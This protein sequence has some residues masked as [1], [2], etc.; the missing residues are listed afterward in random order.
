MDSHNS[1]ESSSS[2][3][4]N[5]FAGLAISRPI[6]E[7]EDD[8]HLPMPVM[9]HEDRLAE[10]MS[11]ESSDSETDKCE[12]EHE[13][14]HVSKGKPYENDVVET[15]VNTEKPIW[16]RKYKKNKQRKKQKQ[17]KPKGRQHGKSTKN[18]SVGNSKQASENTQNPTNKGI[19]G[20]HARGANYRQQGRSGSQSNDSDSDDGHKRNNNTKLP[21]GHYVGLQ[22]E[23]DEQMSVDKSTDTKAPKE[24]S[25]TADLVAQEGCVTEI[26]QLLDPEAVGLGRIWNFRTQG[27]DERQSQLAAMVANMVTHCSHPTNCDNCIKP[28]VCNLVRTWIRHYKSCSYRNIYC[29][30]CQY[31]V[32]GVTKHAL[33]CDNE[34]CEVPN[35]HF[36]RKQLLERNARKEIMGTVLHSTTSIFKEGQTVRQD[37]DYTYFHKQK[38]GHG[39]HG[40][41]HR[42]WFYHLW[43]EVEADIVAKEVTYDPKDEAKV[44]QAIRHDHPN[45]LG[46]TLVVRFPALC[47]KLYIREEK[48]I[49]GCIFMERGEQTLHDLKADYRKQYKCGLPIRDAVYYLRQTLEGLR[50][51]H[52]KKIVHK[53]IKDMNIMMFEKNQ[54]IKIS[55]WDGALFIK[56]E[57]SDADMN[58]VG[59]P[60]FCAPE[61]VA[62]RPHGYPADIFSAAIMLLELLYGGQYQEKPPQAAAQD[63]V[64]QAMLYNRVLERRRDA[65]ERLKREHRDLGEV[66]ERCLADNPADRPTAYQMVHNPLLAYEQN[67]KVKLPL[68]SKSG[69]NADVEPVDFCRYADL[70]GAMEYPSSLFEDK[71]RLYLT[72]DINSRTK[73][74][75]I[76]LPVGWKQFKKSE[77]GKFDFTFE[78]EIRKAAIQELEQQKLQEDHENEEKEKEKAVLASLINDNSENIETQNEQGMGELVNENGGTSARNDESHVDISEAPIL[79]PMRVDNDPVAQKTNAK[80]S[81]FKDFNFSE[82]EDN[83]A[84]PFELVELQT[85]DDIDELKSVLQPESVKNGTCTKKA[86]VDGRK[87]DADIDFSIFNTPVVTKK[88]TSPAKNRQVATASLLQG[89]EPDV[90]AAP[91]PSVAAS[92]SS[93]VTSYSSAVSSTFSSDLPTSMI[94]SDIPLESRFDLIYNKTSSVQNS[95]RNFMP[96]SYSVAHTSPNSSGRYGPAAFNTGNISAYAPVQF[97]PQTT[98]LNCARN[99]NGPSNTPALDSSRNV[100]VQ[101]NTHGMDS[102]GFDARPRGNSNNCGRSVPEAHGFS[103]AYDVEGLGTFRS[104][105][106]LNKSNSKSLPNLAESALPTAVQNTSSPPFGAPEPVV[107]RSRIDNIM[108]QFQFNRMREFDGNAAQQNE[109]QNMSQASCMP[110]SVIPEPRPLSRH[111][112][113]PPLSPSTSLTSNTV[114]P[115]QNSPFPTQN[116]PFPSQNSPFPDQNLPFPNNETNER[117]SFSDGENGPGF[118]RTEVMSYLSLVNKWKELGFPI[119]KIHDALKNT[120]RENEGMFEYLTS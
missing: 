54:R 114:P 46:A 25:A 3:I 48:K 22:W 27:F 97:G 56:N 9:C 6:T 87:P 80:T 111:G 89:I 79:E 84:T 68:R 26:C 120:D 21:K 63:K 2:F 101:S 95:P 1:F 60:G 118:G 91:Y 32:C 110:D 117:R 47:D 116:S 82:F 30:S 81:V 51:L 19:P 28:E 29:K 70:A 100:N 38:L 71:T 8:C 49:V 34:E 57:M 93:A 107:S 16:K 35:C 45:L 72:Y 90:T 42:I 36:Y 83:S 85:L 59:T 66:I 92:Y 31:L 99:I 88:Q 37:V 67:Y 14:A 13:I 73:D 7:H 33:E 96:P 39:S 10:E 113:L 50:F 4:E 65:L 61:V 78:E 115:T 94:S 102:H 62:R 75:K 104:S 23:T 18:N 64:A 105:T 119:Q 103:P 12:L 5:T 58:P 109:A 53:D 108:K 52:D 15:H 24:A 98:P 77:I 76:K 106:N 17:R 44:H 11:S 69:G 20:N 74:M 112:A 86:S 40:H 43:K 55:D 41:V